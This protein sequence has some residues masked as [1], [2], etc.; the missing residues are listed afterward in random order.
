MIYKN[1]HIFK[2][3]VTHLTIIL[4]KDQKKSAIN[5]FLIMLVGMF[6]EILLLNNCAND[7]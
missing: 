2:E 6:L 7:F 3:L 4:S 5:L 1:K